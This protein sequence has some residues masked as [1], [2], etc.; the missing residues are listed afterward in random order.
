MINFQMIKLNKFLPITSFCLYIFQRIDLVC[1]S[2]FR[3]I[4]RA[5]FFQ[6]A[7]IFT[8]L[9]SINYFYSCFAHGL[10]CAFFKST[11]LNWVTTFTKYDLH[12]I[13]SYSKNWVTFFR[14]ELLHA[15]KLWFESIFFELSYWI[16]INYDLNQFFFKLSCCIHINYDLNQFFSNWVTALT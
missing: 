3:P 9:I 5:N 13:L 10:S 1:F 11:I 4:S 6:L 2:S 15:H 14:T 8:L 7:K 16:H 12:H